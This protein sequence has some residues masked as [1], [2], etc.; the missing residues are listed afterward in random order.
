MWSLAKWETLISKQEFSGF[1]SLK[2]C[3]SSFTQ[4]KGR[5]KG[6]I[7]VVPDVYFNMFTN[8]STYQLGMN[9]VRHIH[10]SKTQFN[11]DP[12]FFH[13]HF[14]QGHTYLPFPASIFS[15]SLS[16]TP[17]A[18]IDNQMGY[19][20]RGTNTSWD[21]SKRTVPLPKHMNLWYS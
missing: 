13:V 17:P 19:K 14:L 15:H 21:K 11:W 18:P 12:A 5:L 3:L 4:S 9:H 10:T 6:R 2:Q 1:P 8:Q 7:S 16:W 20:C